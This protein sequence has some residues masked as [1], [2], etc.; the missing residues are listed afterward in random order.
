[1]SILDDNLGKKID[2]NVLDYAL[3]NVDYIGT[4][5]GLYEWWVKS[6]DN[7]ELRR[8]GIIGIK[9]HEFKSFHLILENG[10]LLQVKYKK[11]FEHTNLWKK[12]G[13]YEIERKKQIFREVQKYMIIKTKSDTQVS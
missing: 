7:S 4:F 3:E 11:V 8:P 1:M 5:D 6:R 9:C 12:I 13:R 2:E 10:Q